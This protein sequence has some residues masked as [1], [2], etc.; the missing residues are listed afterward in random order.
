ME[1]KHILHAGA[2]ALLTDVASGGVEFAMTGELT[3]LIAGVPGVLVGCAYLVAVH[4]L[5]KW[6]KQRGEVHTVD[7]DLAG[8]HWWKKIFSRV[9]KIGQWTQKRPLKT[10]VE[11]PTEAKVQTKAENGWMDEDGAMKLLVA[12]SLVRLRLPN[13]TMTVGE[14]LLR[15]QGLITSPTGSSIRANEIARHLLKTYNDECP[16]GKRNGLYYREYL[17][18]WIGEKA[19]QD[20]DAIRAKR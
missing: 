10:I 2:A 3:P 8:H 12:S 11:G 17:E 16:W 4:F 13:D 7:A 20:H 14:T 5:P 6:K 9:R 18:D 19:Y 1:S 15:H